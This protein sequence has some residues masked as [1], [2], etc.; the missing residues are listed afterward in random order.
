M[1]NHNKNRNNQNIEL[2]NNDF[3]GYYH[4]SFELSIEESDLQ[5][6]KTIFI[7]KKFLTGFFCLVVYFSF[8]TAAL[9]VDDPSEK[10]P[11]T[12]FLIE[13]KQK[14]SE[15]QL[16]KTASDLAVRMLMMA[17]FSKL[18]Q[19]LMFETSQKM[20]SETWRAGEQ[21]ELLEETRP[22]VEYHPQQVIFMP[23]KTLFEKFI[24]PS[25]LMKV[26]TSLF[27]VT[28]GTTIYYL[29][30][31]KITQVITNQIRSFFQQ[32]SFTQTLVR[33]MID[34]GNKKYSEIFKLLP[35][36]RGV[37]Q[38]YIN[39]IEQL[40][41]AI[42]E[43][44]PKQK[45]LK[46]KLHDFDKFFNKIILGGEVIGVK[47]PGLVTLYPDRSDP[48]NA[49]LRQYGEIFKTPTKALYY[50]KHTDDLALWDKLL[51]SDAILV[52]K[53]RSLYALLNLCKE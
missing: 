46:K 53:L 11:I 25:M 42:A 24:E 33:K 52:N 34:Q 4:S 5:D 22:K 31:Q 1:E 37:I 21:L 23:P 10:E 27:V 47:L 45:G 29:Y 48:L 50:F 28:T 35:N 18:T 14:F 16:K 36:F 9:A 44:S 38:N 2:C 40:M 19:R 8:S 49:I 13:F 7:F 3:I 51:Y 32:K 39:T 43:N 20:L 6:K 26:G 15:K 17:L 41:V 30:G 12:L